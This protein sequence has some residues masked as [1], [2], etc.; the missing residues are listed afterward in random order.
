M[1]LVEISNNPAPPGAILSA[2]RTRDGLMLRVARWVAPSNTSGTVLILPGRA[3]FIEKYF[4]TVGMLVRRGFDVV[5]FDWRGQGGSDRELPNSR[6]GHIDDFSIYARDVGSLVDQVLR[7]F[8][9][10]PWFGLAH[11]MGGTVLAAVAHAEPDLFERI[12]LL[13]PMVDIGILPLPRGL[14]T[15]SAGLDLCGMGSAFIPGGGVTSVMRK[16]F[17]DNP[18]TSDP[19]RFARTA[20]VLRA[21]PHL[22]IGDPTISWMHAAFRAMKALRDPDFPRRTIVPALV[23]AG[24][25][26]RIVRPRAIELFAH[27]LKA[28]RLIVMPSARHE[29]LMERDRIRGDFW[30]AFDAFI[31]GERHMSR[32]AMRAYAPEALAS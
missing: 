20:E 21:A 27:R 2:A 19:Q 25:A 5:V 4:E 10:E 15:L 24:G 22:E 14:H 26:D 29:I 30:A 12:V 7:P 1:Q 3:E 32:P 11:S 28:G 6:K 23:F 17:A 13:A 18:L 8:C 31:P 16:P 9:P